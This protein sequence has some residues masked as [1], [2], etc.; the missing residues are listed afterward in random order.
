MTGRDRAVGP[1]RSL[2]VGDPVGDVVLAD[3]LGRSWDLADHV[4]RPVL[5][6]F[7]RHLM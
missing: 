7:H 4:G 3:Q 5:L 2:R 1:D 6:V